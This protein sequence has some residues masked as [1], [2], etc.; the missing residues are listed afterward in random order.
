MSTNF[1]QFLHN[2]KKVSAGY[3]DAT[4]APDLVNEN[5]E[6]LS[7]IY[8]NLQYVTEEEVKL[9]QEMTGNPESITYDDSGEPFVTPIHLEPEIEALINRTRSDRDIPNNGPFYANDQERKTYASNLESE[10]DLLKNTLRKVLARNRV[11]CEERVSLYSMLDEQKMMRVAELKTQQAKSVA[12]LMQIKGMIPSGPD[13]LKK[14][15]AELSTLPTEGF[16][17]VKELALQAPTPQNNKPISRFAGNGNVNGYTTQMLNNGV[18]TGPQS[19]QGTLEDRL[20]NLA[21]NSSSY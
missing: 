20:K 15:M 5:E 16:L 18:M 19:S 3:N 11:L 2:K 14:K 10:N 12:S 7:S 9:I 21:W 6:R 4:I 1:K 17:A 13:S 8:E